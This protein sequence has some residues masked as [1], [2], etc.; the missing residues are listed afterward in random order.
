MRLKDQLDA[1]EL[2]LTRNRETLLGRPNSRVH[3]LNVKSLEKR[4][5]MLEQRISERDSAKST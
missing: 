4:K 3:S 2:A 5:R 1:T